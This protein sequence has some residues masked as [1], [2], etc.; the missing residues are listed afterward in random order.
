MTH[1]PYT[2]LCPSG[3]IDRAVFSEIS[4]GRGTKNG[5][6]IADFSHVDPSE[7]TVGDLGEWFAWMRHIGIDFGRQQIEIAPFVQAFNGGVIIDEHCRTTVPGLFAC[8]EVAAG[9]HGADRLGGNM[10]IGNMVFGTRAGLAASQF[11]LSGQRDVTSYA[12]DQVE[13]DVL[14]VSP[15]IGLKQLKDVTPGVTGVNVHDQILVEELK[16]KMSEHCSVVRTSEGLSEAIAYVESLQGTAGRYAN[17]LL[18]SQVILEAA[19]LRQESRGGHYRPEYPVC[20]EQF[21]APIS[22]R[23]DQESEVIVYSRA[24]LR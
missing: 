4:A 10:M 14:K 24:Y 8:G 3:E 6:L 20:N 11:A 12:F 13:G 15:V 19:L 17:R 22:A 1:A 9:P 5:G 21:G 2:S 18:V 23:L 7:F 16:E